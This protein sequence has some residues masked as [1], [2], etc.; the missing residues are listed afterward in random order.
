MY[1]VYVL[2]SV[3]YD[4]YYIG[5]TDNLERRLFEHNLGKTQSTKAFKP[6]KIVLKE[7][8]E[9]RQEARIREKYLKSA[10]GRRW[11]KQHIRPSGATE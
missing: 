4:K 8:F 2:Y 11:R 10:A 6:W 3:D 9:T 1:Y 7:V 5:M